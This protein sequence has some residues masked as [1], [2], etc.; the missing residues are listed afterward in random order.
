VRVCVCVCVRAPVCV[1]LFVVS[2]Q[3]QF[4]DTLNK[5]VNYET[6]RPTYP[7]ALSPGV[8]TDELLALLRV[9]LSEAGPSLPPA[10]LADFLAA[11]EDGSASN[12]GSTGAGNGSMGRGNGSM[13]ALAARCA[14]LNDA[15]DARRL[16]AD[17]QARRVGGALRPASGSHGPASGSHGPAAEEE[18]EEEEGPSCAELLGKVQDGCTALALAAERGVAASILRAGAR[19]PA[20]GPGVTSGDSSSEEPASESSDSEAG[21]SSSP[22]GARSARAGAA[23][24][25][26]AAARR[27][28]LRARR[29]GRLL[30]GNAA[31]LLGVG[32]TE[33][34][35]FS[36]WSHSEAGTAPMAETDPKASEAAAAGAGGCALRRVAAHVARGVALEAAAAALGAIPTAARA[37]PPP[38]ASSPFASP[39]PPPPPQR[40]RR[41]AAGGGAG[42]GGDAI[43]AARG[44][45]AAVEMA[46]SACPAAAWATALRAGAAALRAEVVPAARADACAKW[47]RALALA[48]ALLDGRASEAGGGDAG[49]SGSQPV[50]VSANAA[51]F[52]HVAGPPEDDIRAWAA[53]R[54]ASAPRRALTCAQSTAARARGACRREILAQGCDALSHLSP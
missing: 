16:A 39:P 29:C 36:P 21:S 33:A 5:C 26:R 37:A 42:G 11:P 38:P 9:L 50:S 34:W 52:S 54:C 45:W 44:P 8:S 4:L 32:G 18:E 53:E 24:A 7:P 31:A 6:L 47:L 10:L 49:R 43:A 40:P 12:N 20:A 41:I 2:T 28:R 51:G 17:L 25:P 30:R 15:L 48:A 23:A 14:A 1:S 3:G 35:G 46:P 22:R 27:A 13:G 19:R